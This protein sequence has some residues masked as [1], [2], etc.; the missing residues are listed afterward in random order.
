MINNI[1]SSNKNRFL[2]YP[3]FIQIILNSVLQNLSNEGPVLELEHLNWKVFNNM[4]KNH[5]KST[6][7]GRVTSL[8]PNMIL[9]NAPIVQEVEEN[10]VAADG[11][12]TEVVI[13]DAPE[14]ETQVEVEVINA[15]VGV[16]I[17][18]EVAE[19]VENENMGANMDD[20]EFEVENEENV[21]EKE[22]VDERTDERDEIDDRFVF[23]NPEMEFELNE[24]A[25]TETVS[26]NDNADNGFEI[27]FL[28]AEVE[29]LTDTVISV[30]PRK[31]GN[32]RCPVK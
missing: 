23:D 32:T 26:D 2:L 8:F 21:I 12:E 14:V 5:A 15:G 9:L 31:S 10:V 3:R 19:I 18:N 16:E 24:N 27:A 20:F 30:T 13:E 7:S 22:T 25:N 28:K 1:D 29:D 4:K 11:V 6:F 17:V